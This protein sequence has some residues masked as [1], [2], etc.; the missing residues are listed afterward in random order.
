VKCRHRFVFCSGLVVIFFLSVVPIS[1]NLFRTQAAHVNDDEKKAKEAG[2]LTLSPT[3]KIEYS[4]TSGTWVSLDVSPDGK[5]I[6]FDLVGHLYMMGVGGGNATAITSGMPFDSQPRFSPDGKEIVFVSDRSGATNVWISNA[7]GANAKQ[8]TSDTNAMFVS[9]SWTSDGRYI[10]VSRMKPKAYL[11]GL[12]LRVYDVAGGSGLAVGPERS[13]GEGQPDKNIVGAISPPDGRYFYYA[14]RRSGPE[15]GAKW[16]LARRDLRTGEEEILTSENGGA[17]RPALSPDGTKLVYATHYQGGA[18]IRVRDLVTGEERWFKH[19]TQR[20]AQESGVIDRDLLPGYAFTPDGQSIVMTYGGKFHR[21]DL[22]TAADTE[23]SFQAKVVRELGPKLNFQT[24]VDEG[25]VEA[26][27]IQGAVESPDGGRIAFSALGHLYTVK[28]GTDEKPKRVTSGEDGEFEPAWSPDG[29]TLAYVSWSPKNGG[30][31]WKVAAD[32]GD[33]AKLTRFTAYYEQPAWASDG[34][35]ILAMRAPRDLALEQRDQWLRPIGGLELVSIPVDGAAATVVTPAAHYS[36]P[37]LVVSEKRIFVTQLQKPNLQ[38]VNYSLVSMNADG[39][40]RREVLKLAAKN[41]WGS[42]FGPPVKIQVSPD[43]SRAIALYRSQVYLF[44]LPI[45][46]GTPPTIDLSAPAV[47]VYR[48]TDVGADFASWA[49]AGE[50]VTWAVGSTYF[51]LP[52][53]ELPIADR[54][55]AESSGAPATN[56]PEQAMKLKPTRQRVS[57]TVPR[58]TPEG[59]VVLRGAKVITMRGDEVLKSAD[60]V[61]HNNR[62]QSVGARGSAKQPQGAKVIDVNGATIVPG[63]IDTHAH[64]FNIKRGVL[65]FENWD[66]LATLAYGITAGRDPQT[67]TSDIFVYQDLSEAGAMI[68]PRAYT[69]GPGI[70]S[71]NDFHSEAEAEKVISRYKDFYRTNMV[72]SYEVGDREQRQFVVEA[73]AKLQVMPTTEGGAEMIMDLTHVIDGFGGNEHQFPIASL[74]SDVTDL[75]AQSGIYYTPTFIIGYYDGPGTEDEYFETTDV[76]NNPKLRHF[77]PL[78]VLDE[79]TSGLHWYRKDK[80]SFQ[81]GAASAGKIQKDGGKVCVG[82]H[83]ELQ[84]ASFHWQL[85]SLQ[86]GGMSP[87][88]ALRSATLNGAEAIGLAQDLGSIEPGKLAD[89]VILSKDPLEDIHN[90]TSVKYVM[91][92][93]VLYEGDTLNEVWPARQTAGPFWWWS[94]HP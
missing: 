53:S 78:D 72:K 39:T 61:I 35:V 4:T 47:S 79:K 37:H 52:L 1:S 83:G 16:Q 17:F 92:N 6:V 9:P 5:T 31:V 10:L 15:E 59:T 90:T 32:G 49:D 60:I 81:T 7:D 18:A 19:P 71:T 22:K 14:T 82:G 80:Y 54:S 13:G 74:H 36:Y 65:D 24:R 29:K 84:G 58:A 56:S 28:R 21:L 85:W 27:L 46:G 91:K 38:N 20:D 26:R 75:V 70:F 63:F 86:A 44:D 51:R 73:C 68:G 30:A 62:I 67:Y 87:L 88:E 48:L 33:P 45:L 69:T 55:A 66:F 77:I 40:D 8:I 3:R 25:P 57:V 89:L 50:T 76:Y 2:G 42:D 23:I 41:I 43:G 93:G 94:D 12:E 11:S 64:W 34:S